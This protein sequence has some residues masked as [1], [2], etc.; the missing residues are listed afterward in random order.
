MLPYRDL[1]VEC[2]FSTPVIQYTTVLMTFWTWDFL[3]NLAIYP[4]KEQGGILQEEGMHQP[5]HD[6]ETALK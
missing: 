4:T 1:S 2:G 5:T 3:L 6:R